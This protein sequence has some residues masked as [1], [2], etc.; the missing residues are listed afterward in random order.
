MSRE[1]SLSMSMT[2]RVGAE[3]SEMKRREDEDVRE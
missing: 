1:G 2:L 3:E